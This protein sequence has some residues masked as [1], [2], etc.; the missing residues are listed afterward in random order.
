MKSIINILK[1]FK[2]TRRFYTMGGLLLFFGIA[3][4]PQCRK[5]KENIEFPYDLTKPD[6]EFVLEKSLAEVSGLSFITD[7][8]VALIQDEIGS[9]FLFDLKKNA[10]TKTIAFSKK[11]DY[12]DLKILGDTGYVLRSDG[13]LMEVSGLLEGPVKEKN[14]KTAL[15]GKNN[16]EGLCFDEQKKL[17]LIACK[18]KPEINKKGKNLDHK[19]AIYSFDPSTNML[20]DTPYVLIDVHEVQKIS[21]G[22]Y[23][24]VIEKLVSFYTKAG[25]VHTFEPSGIAIQ[26]LTR[27]L[28]VISSVGKVLVVIS[29][30]GRLVNAIKLDPAVFKQPEG[31]AFDSAGN[32]FITNEGRKG[33]GNIL[34]FDL[35][36]KI[37]A[38][39]TNE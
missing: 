35:K 34:Q 26:P 13:N 33:K 21:R 32:L 7:D 29:P 5:I 18:G 2:P 9:I 36:N 31:I 25:E 15:S 16:T 19:K 38:F 24:N 27:E 4:N 11:G 37:P 39:Q 22:I 14:L 20:S 8:E 3:L 1:S 28:Y 10:I 17:L 6:N 12:E 30:D 23:S